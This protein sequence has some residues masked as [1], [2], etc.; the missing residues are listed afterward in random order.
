MNFFLSV[1]LDISIIKN[2][3]A[4]SKGKS[5]HRRY[6]KTDFTMTPKPFKVTLQ[7]RFYCVVFIMLKTVR[8]SVF[9]GCVWLFFRVLI[10]L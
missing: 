10:V 5:K 6:V 1:V 4:K 8:G 2:G 7:S 3:T 9:E